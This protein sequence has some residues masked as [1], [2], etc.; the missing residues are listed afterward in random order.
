MQRVGGAGYF[1]F[2]V[3]GEAL[4]RNVFLIELVKQPKIESTKM[5]V[6]WYPELRND[7]RGCSFNECFAMLE[8]VLALLP[9][10]LQAEPI[11]PEALQLCLK[12]NL[13]PYEI[14]LDYAVRA[15]ANGRLHEPGNLIWT[16]DE[17]MLRTL[18]L[19]VFL[20]DPQ[21]S[22]DAAF[23]RSLFSDKIKVKTYLTDRVLTGA[24]KT[25]REK[26]WEVH[27]QSVHFAERRVCMTI[28][29]ALVTQVCQFDGFPG[30]TLER[31]QAQ[32]I[33]PANLPAALCPITG[34][35]LSYCNVPL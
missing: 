29:Y 3:L 35:K 12:N 27:P 4:L 26:R 1:R 6:R 21:Q 15:T 31:L 24:H 11:N 25:N 23:F 28:E 2:P 18:K 9:V 5:Q 34:D 20:T 16:A 17:L 8:D 33:L 13:I 19:R 30:D 10:W 32:R 7:P 14:P 22:L